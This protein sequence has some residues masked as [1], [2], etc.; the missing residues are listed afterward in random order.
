MQNKYFTVEQANK[1]LVLV[2]P[3]TK[4][5]VAKRSKMIALK[6]EIR[7]MQLSENKDILQE[8]IYETTQELK[9][10]SRQITYHLEELEA[11]GCY[12]KDF[13]L[14]VIDFPAIL[15]GKVVFLCWMYGENK[16]CNWHELTTGFES[17]KEIST[18]FTTLTLESLRKREEI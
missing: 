18:E 7:N 13:E 4:D 1:S 2:E 5:I 11:I 9:D 17:R 12:L 6:R 3:I 15:R 10:I 8:S 14:G 16:V